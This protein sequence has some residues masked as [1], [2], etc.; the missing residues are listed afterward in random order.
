MTL[1]NTLDKMKRI[2]IGLNSVTSIVWSTFGTGYTRA[3]FQVDGKTMLS[4]HVFMI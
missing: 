1:S 3:I 2:D 4:M